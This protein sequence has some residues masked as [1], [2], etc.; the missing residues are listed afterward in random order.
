MYAVCDLAL[1]LVMTKTA[2]FLLKDF[3]A[4]PCLP[5]RFFTQPDQVFNALLSLLIFKLHPFLICFPCWNESDADM[6][7]YFQNYSNTKCYLPP[8]L[9]I[10][11]KVSEVTLPL[12]TDAGVFRLCKVAQ[13]VNTI[14]FRSKYFHVFII[15]GKEDGIS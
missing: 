14:F 5:A 1:S 7:W 3:P 2:N 12:M 8:E 4:E 9:I 11:N 15:K 13:H 6:L 10:S